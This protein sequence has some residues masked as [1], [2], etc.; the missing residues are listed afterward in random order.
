[1]ENLSLEQKL[2][3]QDTVEEVSQQL[4][5]IRSSAIRFFMCKFLNKLPKEEFL[6]VVQKI[7]ENNRLYLL[8][9]DIILEQNF[10]KLTG[11]GLEDKLQKLEKK[12]AISD[13]R[14]AYSNLDD[15]FIFKFIKKESEKKC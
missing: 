4:Y 6:Y 3:L 7:K 10:L 8:L 9:Q 2:Y 14:R 11:E 12:Q 15:D 5:L 1:M 13:L